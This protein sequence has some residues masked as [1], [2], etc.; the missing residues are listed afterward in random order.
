[1]S[2]PLSLSYSEGTS[3]GFSWKFSVWVLCDTLCVTATNNACQVIEHGVLR[4]LFNQGWNI[5]SKLCL[6][7]TSQLSP[8]GEG[9][10]LKTS[11]SDSERSVKCSNHILLHKNIR[12]VFLRS[13]RFCGQ[14]RRKLNTISYVYICTC[15]LIYVYWLRVYLLHYCHYHYYYYYYHYI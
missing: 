15:V 3:G 9:V 11:I 7:H 10:T 13:Y 6:F 14:S 2:P 4:L 1:M 12:S 8:S 5:I